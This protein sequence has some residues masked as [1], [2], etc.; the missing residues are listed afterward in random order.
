MTKKEVDSASEKRSSKNICKK[1]ALSPEQI[2][3]ANEN[4]TA[5]LV[6]QAE[7]KL[8]WQFTIV[9]KLEKIFDCLHTAKKLLR[10]FER[11]D[12]VSKEDLEILGRCI[13][14]I[15]RIE[16]DLLSISGLNDYDE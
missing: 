9:G 10:E 15:R 8:E 7:K 14:S 1:N 12:F 16:E 4:E 3:K 6:R 2:N 13:S 5:Q 11:K